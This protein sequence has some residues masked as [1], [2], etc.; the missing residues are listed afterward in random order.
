MRC[1]KPTPDYI[2]L[3]NPAHLGDLDDVRYAV[4]LMLTDGLSERVAEVLLM[5]AEKEGEVTLDQAAEFHKL[6][7]TDYELLCGAAQ[8]LVD[9]CRAVRRC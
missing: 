2:E 5:W 8:D 1:P 7:G 4:D 6:D 3:Y 9:N